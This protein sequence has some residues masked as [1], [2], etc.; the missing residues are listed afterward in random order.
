MLSLLLFPKKNFS[1]E[2]GYNKEH[3]IK[4]KKGEEFIVKYKCSSDNR[5]SWSYIN[6]SNKIE[7]IAEKDYQDK[8]LGKQRIKEYTL[9]AKESTGFSYVGLTFIESFKADYA[10]KYAVNQIHRFE[11]KVL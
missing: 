1:F 2:Y 10:W 8:S 6:L 7:V 3:S 4:V 11:V 9:K 5:Y